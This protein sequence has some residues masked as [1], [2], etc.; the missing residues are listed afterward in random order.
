MRFQLEQL[1]SAPLAVVEAAFVD[2]DLLTALVASPQLGRPEVLERT[3]DGA[4]VRMQVRYAFVGHLPSAAT[5]VIDPARLTWVEHSELD[6]VAHVTTFSIAP[7]HYPDRLTCTGA[8]ALHADGE[9]TR[10]VID[11]DLRVRAPL[12]AGKVE[13]AI[14]SGMR[15]H[16]V[17]EA[18]AVQAWL[19]DR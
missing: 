12:V 6:R 17:A 13:R 8:V 9:S 7:D 16:A 15:E 5:R 3:D 4:L 2:P 18:M 11:A 19:D 14:V 1:F 10:R